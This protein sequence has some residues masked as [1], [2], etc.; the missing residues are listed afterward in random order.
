[1]ILEGVKV[2]D[3]G[4]GPADN[5]SKIHPFSRDHRPE[6]QHICRKPLGFSSCCT[7]VIRFCSD[8][9]FCACFGFGVL[10]ETEGT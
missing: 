6:T 9:L 4:G 1:M 2:S 3:L 8:C 5:I 10:A 7:C